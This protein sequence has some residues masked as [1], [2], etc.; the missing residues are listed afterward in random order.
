M[1]EPLIE[2]LSNLLNHDDLQVGQTYR[3]IQ[4]GI[5]KS[6]EIVARG[7]GANPA[8][9]D[10]NKQIIRAI[11]ERKLPSSIE[12]SKRVWRTINRL[13]NLDIDVSAETTDY[14]RNLQSE[15]KAIF[16]SPVGARA[17][18]EQLL[19]QSD[20]LVERAAKLSNAVYVYSFPSYLQFGTIENPELKWMKVGKT[21]GL[22]WQRLK[23][24]VRQTSMPEDPVLLRIYHS[25]SSDAD[26]IEK[27][28][29]KVL[30]AFGHVRSA[31]SRTRAGKEWFATTE[32]ALDAL[33]EILGLEIESEIDFSD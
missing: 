4:D 11:L 15:L 33:A 23:D 14:L 25:P 6:K 18:E 10:I 2:E 3:L 24:Q 19:K 28:F 1:N 16:D 32:D 12:I 7:V 9:V 5:S 21:E 30:D 20:T 22:V 27:T 26:T 8:V 31:A 29:H 13:L 17:Y